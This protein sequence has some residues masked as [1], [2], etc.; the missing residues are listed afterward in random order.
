MDLHENEP[1]EQ[2]LS[3]VFI[4]PHSVSIGKNILCND[5]YNN[6]FGKS[7]FLFY[8]SIYSKKPDRDYIVDIAITDINGETEAMQKL[9]TFDTLDSNDFKNYIKSIFLM[10]KPFKRNILNFEKDKQISMKEYY[11]YIQIWINE[12]KNDDKDIQ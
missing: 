9:F 1:K 11:D 6:I 7:V 10:F 3:D 8:M 5:T 2:D 4:F 12:Q